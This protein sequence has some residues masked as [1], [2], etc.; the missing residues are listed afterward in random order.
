MQE[1]TM[2]RGHMFLI[3]VLLGAVFFAG[4][5]AVSRTVLLGQPANAS[6][7]SDPA[8]TFRLKRL[9]RLEASLARDAARL[10]PPAKAQQVTVYRHAPSAAASTH[11]GD[12][13]D[14]HEH[15]EHEETA[16]D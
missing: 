14:D 6:T 11:D 3:T 7:T 10:Q 4:A 2:S 12:D 9:D 5:L 13:G 1:V 8:I 16:D 15:D